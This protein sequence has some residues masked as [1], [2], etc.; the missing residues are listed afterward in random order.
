MYVCLK[1]VFVIEMKLSP[2]L[3]SSEFVKNENFMYV[4][5][6]KIRQYNIKKRM[7]LFIRN[8]INTYLTLSHF[9]FA[10]VIGRHKSSHIKNIFFV[11]ILYSTRFHWS[12]KIHNFDH[13][14]E[15]WLYFQK[16]NWQQGPFPYGY[17]HLGVTHTSRYQKNLCCLPRIALL[18]L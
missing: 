4:Q 18:E 7:W 6:L 15:K 9:L 1:E 12:I 2:D 14:L 5:T 17:I 13:N 11:V 8:L 3:Y 16:Y 10:L